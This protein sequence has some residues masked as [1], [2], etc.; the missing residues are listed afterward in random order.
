[1]WFCV[2]DSVLRRPLRLRMAAATRPH[3]FQVHGAACNQRVVLPPR[4]E[5]PWEEGVG[6]RDENWD[7]M[8]PTTGWTHD[9]YTTAPHDHP[10]S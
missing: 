5:M 2:F 1:M 6:D 9:R 10:L 3:P 4:V 8:G 7:L